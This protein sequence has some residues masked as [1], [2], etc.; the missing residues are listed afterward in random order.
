MDD[1]AFQRRRG[2]TQTRDR[3]PLPLLVCAAAHSRGFAGAALADVTKEHGCH[4][5][6][7]PS[8]FAT[9]ELLA[10]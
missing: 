1:C 7:M 3:M 8:C 4:S 9:D 6:D 5:G 2:A 10:M